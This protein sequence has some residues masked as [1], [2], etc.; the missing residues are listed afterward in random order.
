M[1]TAAL[2]VAGRTNPDFLNLGAGA[3]ILFEFH[4]NPTIFGTILGDVSGLTLAPGLYSWTTA[5]IIPTD[6]TI[7]GSSTDSTSQ[8]LIPI[9]RV[10]VKGKLLTS[11]DFPSLRHTHNVKLEE[12]YASWRCGSA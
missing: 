12:N 3:S 5:L 9:I 1:Q 7:S 2:D 6:V 8:I 11:L 10:I 4:I